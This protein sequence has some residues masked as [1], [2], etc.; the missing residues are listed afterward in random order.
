[1][2]QT[3]GKLTVLYEPPRTT[4]LSPFADA[5]LVVQLLAIRDNHPQWRT[6]RRE[7]GVI[8]A[9]AYEATLAMT[10]YRTR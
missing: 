9:H 2:K 1:M 4:R 7:D 5:A 3:E 10:A 8:A 6:N